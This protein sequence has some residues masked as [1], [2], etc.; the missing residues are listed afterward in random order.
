MWE[1]IAPVHHLCVSECY[2]QTN[3]SHHRPG[4]GIPDKKGHNRPSQRFKILSYCHLCLDR[5]SSDSLGYHIC[6]RGKQHLCWDMDDVCS[7]RS[8]HVLGNE[9]FSKSEVFM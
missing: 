1:S 7:D 8:L 9:L 6:R 4:A 2:F 3:H 5:V